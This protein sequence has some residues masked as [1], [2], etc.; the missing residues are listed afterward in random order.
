[1]DVV[2]QGDRVQGS[3]LQLSMLGRLKLALKQLQWSRYRASVDLHQLSCFLSM[4]VRLYEPLGISVAQAV[5]E[6]SNGC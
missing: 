5:N 2:A 3:L 6:T 4:E 1:M